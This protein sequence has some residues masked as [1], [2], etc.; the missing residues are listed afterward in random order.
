MNVFAIAPLNDDR[1]DTFVASHQSASIFHTR[2]WLR[3][4]A[5]TYGYGSIALTTSAPG[6]P[7]ANALPLCLVPSRLTGRR[8]VSLPFADHCQLLTDNVETLSALLSRATDEAR[9]ARCRYVE[10]RPVEVSNALKAGLLPLG[11]SYQGLLHEIDLNDS[12]DHIFAQFNARSTVRN[13]RRSEKEKLEYASGSED[14]LLDA[15]YAMQIMTRRRHRLPPQPRAWFRNLLDS[16]GAA[17]KIHVAYK[18]TKPVAAIFT[19]AF[20]RRYMYKY[21]AS[22]PAAMS[23]GGTH[24]LIWRAIQEAKSNGFA[25][26]D[27]GRTD[28]GHE[29]LKTF[30]SRWGAH[31]R[32]LHYYRWPAPTEAE[33]GREGTLVRL[34]EPV[35]ERLPDWML[36]RAGQLLYRHMG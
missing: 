1:W 24:L 35:F 16:L 28:T 18:D 3:A 17:A 9:A 12:L 7:L 25:C 13:I 10:I 22:D 21:G 8:L 19:C 32:P 31:P 27:M 2:G 11:P 6:D 4:L 26:F 34:A 30:K 36:I 20:G 5:D 23:L 33:D 29:G 14:E 15:F